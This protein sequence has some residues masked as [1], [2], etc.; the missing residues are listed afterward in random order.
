MVSPFGLGLKP[1]QKGTA[2]GRSAVSLVPFHTREWCKSLLAATVQDFSLEDLTGNSKEF[3]RAS[4]QLRFAWAA[5]HLALLDS[6]LTLEGE[7]LER[8]G[9]FV[10]LSRFFVDRLEYLFGKLLTN[11]VHEILPLQVDFSHPNGTAAHLTYLYN[12]YGPALTYCASCQS[13]IKALESAMHML[14]TNVID[15]A[16]VLSVDVLTPFQ[17]H[18]EA[19]A[20]I[21]SSETDMN[22]HPRPFD[23]DADGSVPGEGAV[24][25]ILERAGDSKARKSKNWGHIKSLT[26]LNEPVPFPPLDDKYSDSVAQSSRKLLKNY[27][28]NELDFLHVDGRGIKL[29][30]NALYRGIQL[31]F[32]NK[33]STL[34]ITSI[35]GSIGHTGGSNGLF[36][37]VSTVLA[38]HSSS[39]PPIRNLERPCGHNDLDY[40]KGESRQAKLRQGLALSFGWGGQYSTIQMRKES[41]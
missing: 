22:S 33:A 24:A 37:L 2:E 9:L 17:F 31:A 14:D 30:D 8:T 39:I 4:P 19:S 10:G 23:K 26:T 1:F 34:P 25:L 13:G 41:A 20:G 12:I 6:S 21:L 38:L 11:R 29:L 18:S 40:V 15:V 28:L 7:L 35:Q 32:T 3:R 27:N 16:I 5:V 36:Q